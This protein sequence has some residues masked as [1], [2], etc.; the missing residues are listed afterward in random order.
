[1][2]W[3]VKFS[4]G[5][6]LARAAAKTPTGYFPCNALLVCFDIQKGSKVRVRVRVRF[7]VRARVRV[8]VRAGVESGI[9]DT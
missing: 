6:V 4:F 7:R 5:S 9:K 3:T 2:K 8:G 1:V